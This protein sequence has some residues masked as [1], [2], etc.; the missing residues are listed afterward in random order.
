MSHA[1]HGD[2][3]A[4]QITGVLKMKQDGKLE[5]MSSIIQ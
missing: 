2:S 1:P 4:R 3:P 5:K